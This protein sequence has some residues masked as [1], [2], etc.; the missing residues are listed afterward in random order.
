VLVLACGSPTA[1]ASSPSP[2]GSPSAS[3]TAVAGGSPFACA[4]VSGG[5]SARANVVAVRADRNPGFDRFV[6]EFDGAVPGYRVTRQPSAGFTEDPSGRQMT[7]DGTAG[8]LVRLEPASSLPTAPIAVSPRSTVLRDARR[9]GDFEAVVRWGLGLAA[10][11]CFRVLTL[12]APSRL[13]IDFQ[14]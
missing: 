2:S 14:T 11:A 12:S 6:L 5:G 3:P 4:D 8:V 9:V 7:L 1:P 13:V 10:P